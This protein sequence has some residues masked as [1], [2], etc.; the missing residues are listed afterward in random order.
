MVDTASTS[1][2]LEA[3]HAANDAVREDAARPIGVFDSGVGGLSVAREIRRLLPAED[4]LYLADRAHCPYG[5]RSPDE[6]RA[7]ARAAAGALLERG[8]KLIVV[9]CNTASEDRFR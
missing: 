3:T 9:A 4:I 2:A 8:A 7:L 1:A 6:I 5:G